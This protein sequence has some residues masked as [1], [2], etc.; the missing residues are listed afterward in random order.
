MLKLNS[1]G[2]RFDV[3]PFSDL[4]Q[5]SP[6]NHF[7]HF[8]AFVFPS[9]Y[10]PLKVVIDF[11]DK[12]EVC[13]EA[14]AWADVY[15]VSNLEPDGNAEMKGPRAGREEKISVLGPYFGIKLFG[16]LE[17]AFLGLRN[18]FL[19]GRY[20]SVS[21]KRRLSSYRWQSVRPELSS[22]TSGP[23]DECYVF[24][25]S[26]LYGK[27]SNSEETNKYRSAFI[28]AARRHADFEGGLV[29]RNS[30]YVDDFF[31]DVTI[32]NGFTQEEYASKTRKSNIV[33]NTP[34]VWG[35]IGWK[36]GEYLA[37][38]N[39]IISMPLNRALP[40]PLEHGKHIFFVESEDQID[41]AVSELMNDPGLRNRLQNGARSYFD[42]VCSPTASI[43]RL[44]TER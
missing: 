27:Q 19:S 35:C 24:H 2:I 15:G 26:T 8:F 10:G 42:E 6:E 38:G 17:T 12:T 44:I 9:K 28:R 13:S 4:P 14:L 1:A 40:L 32:E 5:T 20:T 37:Y 33:F 3:G 43:E 34:S 18:H 7:D 30:Q 36:L 31:R 11:R 39:A 29:A 23:K 22:F 25:A 41:S 16:T 21:L